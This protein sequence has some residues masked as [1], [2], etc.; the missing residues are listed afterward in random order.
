MESSTPAI[1]VACDESGND[2]ENLFGGDAAVFAHASV[3]TSSE[4]A[5][6]IMAELR[7]RTNAQ[8]A[9]LTS[10]DILRPKTLNSAQWLL[11]HP[12]VAGCSLVH[13]TEKRYFLTCKLFDSTVESRCTQAEPTS[14]RK[15]WHYES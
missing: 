1:V 7:H 10:K 14:T 15:T 3:A 8:P 2:G 4:Q 12:A 5:G 11:R 9:E 6:A 13:L